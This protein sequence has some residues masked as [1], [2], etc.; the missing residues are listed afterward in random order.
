MDERLIG[1]CRVIDEIGKGGMAVVYRAVQESLNR[2][3]AIKELKDEYADDEV[4][5]ERFQREA[6]S[7]ASFQHENIVH[8]YDYVVD[9]PRRYIIM[10]YVEGTN[11]FDLL[12]RVERLPPDIAAIIA[13]QLARALEYAHFRGVV[14]RDI[15]P[16][17]VVIS[18]MGEVKLMDFG[19]ARAE[20]LGDMTRPGV[21][22]GT[23][24]YMSPEQVMGE[25]VDWRSDIFSFGIVL[26]QMLTGRKP[27]R[28][29]D[30]RTVMQVILKDS[31]TPS[32]SLFPDIPR[33]LARVVARCLRKRPEERY[34][35][36]E[37]L[38]AALEGYINRRVRIN[39]CGRVV[40]F[41]HHR[42][43]LSEAEALTVLTQEVLSQ[44]NLE[45]LDVSPPSALR[46]QVVP[47]AMAAVLGLGV[48]L[49]GAGIA[50]W[51]PSSVGGDAAPQ[52]AQGH[53]RINVWPW[54][55]V[56]VDGVYVDTTPFMR[57]VP[58]APGH[59]V[60]ELRNEYFEDER[61]EFEIQAERTLT[62]N[63][64]MTRRRET[65]P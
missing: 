38:R 13:L 44:P 37:E 34:L 1:N 36:T 51:W 18:K 21:A 64:E 35:S 4:I 33:A 60:I 16:S 14:H 62:F 25:R 8:V 31:Y 27:F 42:G 6:L 11:I 61:R 52:G 12:N 46:S 22:L 50:Q 28:E 56:F 23:P 57:A 7:V 39:P 20:A 65:T 41:L 49:A 15:K 47:V 19:I 40:A 59:H 2:P 29:T 32:R 55:R 48:L 43:L 17:N 45:Q 54:A 5:T 10:E 26:Y 9:G 58:L 24:S 53:L 3:V 63:V 30:Q